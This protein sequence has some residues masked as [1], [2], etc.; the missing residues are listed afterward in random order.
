[1]TDFEILEGYYLAVKIKARR[2]GATIDVTGDDNSPS[3]IRYESDTPP[4]PVPELA[5]FALFAAGLVVVRLK[6]RK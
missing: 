4:Y 1:M 6:I 2:G 5:T 3:F